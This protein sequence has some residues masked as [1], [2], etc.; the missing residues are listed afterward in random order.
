MLSRKRSVLMVYWPRF[1]ESPSDVAGI[2]SFFHTL[3]CNENEIASRLVPSP[4]TLPWFRSNAF[5]VRE[6][7]GYCQHTILAAVSSERLQQLAAERR[8]LTRPT[9]RHINLITRSN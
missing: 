6:N 9:I 5:D 3:S 2:L 8:V 7:P 1:H 4:F